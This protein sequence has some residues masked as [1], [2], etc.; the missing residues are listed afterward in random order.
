DADG[1]PDVAVAYSN[2]LEP[3]TQNQH[4]GVLVL[5]GRG[6]GTFQSGVKTSLE[7]AAGQLAVN[8]F[9]G[10]GKPD[11]IAV[12]VGAG[13]LTLFLG[14]GDG[15]FKPEINFETGNEPVV[16][17]VDDFNRDGK[18]DLAVMHVN[19]NRGPG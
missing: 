11:V 12:D 3:R 8:D 19:S 7:R 17:G 2:F 1:K 18:P 9:N 16:A 14:L 13:M 10:D 5:L 15:T 4:G 6:D